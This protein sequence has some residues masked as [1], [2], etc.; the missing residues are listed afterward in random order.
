MVPEDVWRTT[1]DIPAKAKAKVIDRDLGK[2]ALVVARHDLG[3]MLHAALTRALV[4]PPWSSV[5]GAYIPLV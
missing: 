2:P 1:P 3:D 4:R 5:F